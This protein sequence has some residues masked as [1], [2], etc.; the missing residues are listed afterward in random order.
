ME[1]L[2]EMDDEFVSLSQA[3]E[4]EASQTVDTL[5]PDEERN[6]WHIVDNLYRRKPE[7]ILQA[8]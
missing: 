7:L 3:C 1:K 5:P 6:V 8:N 2:C 4:P